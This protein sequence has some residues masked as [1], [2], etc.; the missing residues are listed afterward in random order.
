MNDT[1]P[2]VIIIPAKVE[3]PQEQEKKRHLRVA[4]YCRVS[5]DSEEQLS[6]YEN[7][8]SYYTEKIMKEPGW[9]MAGVFADEGITGT[10]TCKR[11]EFLRMI[12]QYRQGKIDMI[13]AKS[14]S[15]FAC[16]TVDTLNFTR[17][18]RSLGIPVVF[19]EQNINSIYPESE[20][21]ITLHGAFAQAESESTSSRVRWGKQQAMRSGHV[22][23]NYKN[24]LGYEKGLD[25][26][27]AIIPEQAETVRFIYDRYL[28]GDSIRE[29]KA[30][31]EGQRIP[32]VSGKAEWMASHIRSILT[33]EKYCGDV[34]LQKNFIQ[35]C[36]SK[37]VIPNTGQLPKYLIQNQHEGIVSRETFDAVQLEM[38]R[39]NA[40]A[41]DTRKSTPTGRGKYS[42]K[43]VLS[44]LL[45]CGECG[46]AY[47][48]C[49]WTQRGVKRPVWRCVSR[50]DYGK[51]FCT[52]SP[53]L[54]EE[55]LQQA[56]LA[57][58]NAVMLDRDTL[59]RQLAAVMEWELAPMLGESMSLAD[60]DRALEELSSQFNSLLAEASANP[61]EDYTERFRELSE[62][63][64]RLKE[65]KAQLEGA[66]QE[67]GR[68]QSRLRA[69][70]AA[71]EHMTA[72]MTEWDEEVIHQLLEKVTV[73]SRE[74]IRVTFRDGREIEQY[75][76][77]PKRRKLA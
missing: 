41:G 53:T 49:V 37:K 17:E 61:A 32:T 10:S 40:K 18:L 7:Q 74:K 27:P 24:L 26:K 30:A 25:G 5:T 2:N 47:R 46:T 50:L 68:L 66:C 33:N 6:S 28:A 4:A 71:M 72:A 63:T 59:A 14:V 77:Q 51:E 22:T 48:R 31:L 52:Q 39:R 12:R 57:A 62:S 55:P 23:I 35:D 45:F 42:G 20:F 11:K 73:L 13:L 9:T 16:N 34:L 29:I 19:E 36:I 69:V 3:T 8:L 38:A 76:A 60:I 1:A 64:A 21:L 56:I 54:D 58:V 65:R 67:Q 75:V 70:S 43:H 44:K 15:R